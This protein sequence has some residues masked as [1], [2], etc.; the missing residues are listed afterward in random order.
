MTAIE[1]LEI[2]GGRYANG[3]HIH[4]SG[5]GNDLFAGSGTSRRG[6]DLRAGIPLVL[7]PADGCSQ[8]RGKAVKRKWVGCERLVGVQTVRGEAPV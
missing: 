3:N 5:G 8:A 1:L 7:C 2:S 4:G 6:I